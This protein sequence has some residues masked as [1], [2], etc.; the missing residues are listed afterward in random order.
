MEKKDD[1]PMYISILLLVFINCII[2]YHKES[3]KARERKKLNSCLE[4]SSFLWATPSLESESRSVLLCQTQISP[5]GRSHIKL[6]VSADPFSR[7]FCGCRGTIKLHRTISSQPCSREEAAACSVPSA[8]AGKPMA[9][10]HRE[11]SHSGT[12]AGSPL[13][14][15]SQHQVK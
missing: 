1:L 11:S 8:V 3:R 13:Q 12:T 14:I 4:H 7:P 2:I 15:N 10:W 5:A 6:K 9:A